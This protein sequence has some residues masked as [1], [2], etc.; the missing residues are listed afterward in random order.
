MGRRF[1]FIFFSFLFLIHLI[2][3]PRRSSEQQPLYHIPT[4]SF[5][6]VV[7]R[8]IGRNAIKLRYW[9]AGGAIA[10]GAAAGSVRLVGEG[11]N[12]QLLGG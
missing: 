8:F 9:V 7:L 2:L 12:N 10:G 5:T 3:I 6:G 11:N 1:F 4:R